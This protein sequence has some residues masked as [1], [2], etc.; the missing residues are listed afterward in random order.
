MTDRLADTLILIFLLMPRE[1]EVTLDFERLTKGFADV[2][3]TQFLFLPT[4]ALM[5]YPKTNESPQH[6]IIGFF[7]HG[8]FQYEPFAGDLFERVTY[9]FGRLGLTSLVENLKKI[10]GC[11]A[12]HREKV[13]TKVI[14]FDQLGF[15]GHQSPDI[16]TLMQYYFDDVSAALF[17]Q[18]W[19]A[20]LESQYVTAAA[21]A[22]L[23]DRA[24]LESL[25]GTSWLS[26]YWGLNILGVNG[27][28]SWIT[29]ETHLKANL[30]LRVYSLGNELSRA[31]E[32]MQ[33]ELGSGP[34]RKTS[35][36]L[37]FARLVARARELQNKSYVEESFTL[38]MVAIESLVAGRDSISD[39]LSRRVG[40][41]WAISAD[42]SFQ[43]C[44]K[45]V[46]RL[47]D[48]R[49][50][51]VHEGGAINVEALSVLQ[52]LCRLVF[53]AAYRSQARFVDYDEIK[54][55]ARWVSVLD[56][57]C[58]CFDVMV[59]VDGSA[60]EMSGALRPESRQTSS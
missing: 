44:F 29:E 20:H 7:G 9:R 58:A 40:A 60:T 24:F 16:A 32:R 8:A 41:L 1:G 38:L 48:S 13:R 5:T 14:D 42:K 49:S 53:F 17:E 33:A 39:T 30:A 35:S 52:E 15:T 56:Y 59:P 4:S 47:Y 43:D 12:L 54:W 2:D 45:D 36:L 23:L 28:I 18:F 37:N 3:V 25:H 51:F 46:Q 50:R 27:I 57:I 19:K 34:Y 26:I 21:G 55:K 11:L 10:F 22:D 31:E 6:D